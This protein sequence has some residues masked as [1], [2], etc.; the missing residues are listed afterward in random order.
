MKNHL[1]I[2]LH[3]REE[4]KERTRVKIRQTSL[5][6]ISGER[7]H[8]DVLFA[9]SQLATPGTSHQVSSAVTLWSA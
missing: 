4:E 1:L 6:T 2:F 3:G 8:K 5:I 9:V 7:N